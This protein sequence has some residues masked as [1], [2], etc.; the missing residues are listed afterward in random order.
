MEIDRF[1]F[2]SLQDGITVFDPPPLA[3]YSTCT[4]VYKVKKEKKKS[5][6]ETK[7]ILF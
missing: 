7:S 3:K 2:F 1:K 5:K 4:F 6:F